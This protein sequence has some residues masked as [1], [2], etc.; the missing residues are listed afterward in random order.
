MNPSLL[1]S[2]P[3]GRGASLL[4]AA[5]APFAL[6]LSAAPEPAAQPE[7][8][9]LITTHIYSDIPDLPREQIVNASTNAVRGVITEVVPFENGD[10]W[11]MRRVG[12]TV[13]ES[14]RGTT[15]EDLKFVTHGGEV[16][17][18]RTISSDAPHFAVGEEVVLYL[19]QGAG[20]PYAILTAESASCGRVFVD[21]QGEREVLFGDTFVDYDT[22]VLEDSAVPYFP[23]LNVDQG[24]QQQ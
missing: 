8:G 10:D 21:E 17:N 2:G 13:L 4:L 6:I 7:T 19:F 5:A 1:P 9:D 15:P 12:V 22:L 3:I 11:I 20:M 24:G 23:T 14:W 16:G 18:K